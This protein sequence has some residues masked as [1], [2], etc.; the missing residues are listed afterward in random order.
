[1]KNPSDAVVAVMVVVMA[2]AGLTACGQK[3]EAG[4]E[5]G[6]GGSAVTGSA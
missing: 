1:M 6:Q 2:S 3:P 4:T 5:L